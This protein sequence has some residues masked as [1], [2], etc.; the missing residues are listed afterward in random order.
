MELKNV[1]CEGVAWVNAI[2]DRVQWRDL[3]HKFGLHK[4]RETS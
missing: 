1:S 2:Q 4:R 3:L